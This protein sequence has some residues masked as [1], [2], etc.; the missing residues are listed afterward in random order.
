MTGRI[1]N[2]PAPTDVRTGT[3]TDSGIGRTPGADR[4][5]R[6]DAE[7]PRRDDPLGA[8]PRRPAG[9]AAEL[10]AGPA[11]RAALPAHRAATA[12][13]PPGL[14]P[15]HRAVFNLRTRLFEESIHNLQKLCGE[16]ALALPPAGQQQFDRLQE[17]HARLQ[18]LQPYLLEGRDPPAGSSV[19]TRRARALIDMEKLRLQCRDDL[20]ELIVAHPGHLVPML[21]NADLLQVL[22]D[23]LGHVLAAD[24]RALARSAPEVTGYLDQVNAAMKDSTHDGLREA[25]LHSSVLQLLGGAVEGFAQDHVDKHRH[26][27]SG[28]LGRHAPQQVR[29]AA[30]HVGMHAAVKPQHYGVGLQTEL[31]ARFGRLFD[32]GVQGERE[33]RIRPRSGVEG[34]FSTTELLSIVE[35]MN[36]YVGR[37]RDRNAVQAAIQASPDLQWVQVDGERRLQLTPEA[38]QRLGRDPAAAAAE[39]ADA[40]DVDLS[41]QQRMQLGL[42]GGAQGLK[43][44]EVKA[45]IANSFRAGIQELEERAASMLNLNPGL[46]GAKA[47]LLAALHTQL[48]ACPTAELMLARVEAAIGQHDALWQ[49]D[50]LAR[51][52]GSTG[53]LLADLLDS[54]QR[55]AAAPQ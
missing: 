18:A 16:G 43:L 22:A 53:T 46:T 45:S 4:G 11:P 34:Y 31:S 35:A 10:A 26:S 51:D 17:N 25:R 14:A 21:H 55:Y 33:V 36:D 13:D 30:A 44:A 50:R 52:A 7:P 1:P 3:S 8:L 12:A 28:W 49:A 54:L 29:T 5:P 38:L 23:D 40:G 24:R 15:E 39:A 6:R 37:R 20:C 48:M 2:R 9:R 27:T 32:I 47:S 41:A 42:I 19:E